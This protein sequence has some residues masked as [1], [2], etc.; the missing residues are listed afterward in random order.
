MTLVLRV[1]S[2]TAIYLFVLTSVSPGDILVGGSLALAL[3]VATGFGTS[4]RG[5]GGW[6]RWAV[7]VA[8]MVGATAWE[9][10]L[11]T[12][13]VIRFCLTDAGHP[14]FVEIPRGDR[15]RHAVALWGV[16]TGEAPD[17]YPVTV[18]DR[19]HML[20]V[21]VIDNSDPD[22]VRARHAAAQE[23]HLRDVVA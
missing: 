23:S 16:L 10:T 5:P 6:G 11:G 18:D 2:L 21:H 12:V 19:R 9:M 15:S 3:V 17:E 22:A 14:G 1:G 4:R 7:A 13:R 20:I 8:R